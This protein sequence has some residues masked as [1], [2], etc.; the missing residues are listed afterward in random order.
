VFRWSGQIMASIDG[1]GFIGRNPGDD[2]NVYVVTGDTGNGLTHGTIAG[3]LLPDLIA[4]R[5]N[6]WSALYD[7]GRITPHAALTFAQENLHVAAGYA[8]WLGLGER[9]PIENLRPGC[10]AVFQRGLRKVAV[11]RDEHGAVHECS[12]VCPHLGGV[13]G[14]NSLERSWD[15]PCHGSRFDPFGRV[16]NGPAN[17]D[18]E[19]SRR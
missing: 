2:D 14:W 7:P 17:G 10:G 15:C 18:L 8:H 11:Y 12:A 6:R 5:S 1:L 19:P 9:G 13:V 16:I 3:L 4:G